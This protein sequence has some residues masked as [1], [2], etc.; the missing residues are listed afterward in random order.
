MKRTLKPRY[1]QQSYSFFSIGW[2]FSLF[3][4]TL[5]ARCYYGSLG[6][7]REK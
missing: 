5:L 3:R 2:G 1:M 4:Q 7:S 6:L